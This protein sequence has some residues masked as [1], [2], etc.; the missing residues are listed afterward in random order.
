LR[1]QFLFARIKFYNF[2]R[3]VTGLAFAES[4]TTTTFA[5]LAEVSA[6][7]LLVGSSKLNAGLSY[8]LYKKYIS[9]VNKAANPINR[10]MFV[11]APSF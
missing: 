4:G 6:L 8:L 3:I 7:G 2:Y 11:A 1:H 5:G 10:I 9:P